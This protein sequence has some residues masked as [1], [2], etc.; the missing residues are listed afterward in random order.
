M[1]YS[2]KTQISLPFK[3]KVSVFFF[4][5]V[6]ACASKPEEV[7]GDGAADLAGHSDDGGDAV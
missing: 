4:A 6:A 7:A 1:W 3:L 2:K 5:S